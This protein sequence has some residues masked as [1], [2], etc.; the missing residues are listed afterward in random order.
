MRG[1][2]GFL[3]H[4]VRLTHGQADVITPAHAILED[5][6]ARTWLS[7][8]DASA[9]LIEKARTDS[10]NIGTR[11]P[12]ASQIASTAFLYTVA[13][14]TGSKLRGC[15]PDELKRSVL[16]PDTD[17]ND[18]ENT[19]AA[20]EK[21][22]A[23][24]HCQ[25][26]RYYF[27]VEEQPD[28]KVE[29]RS[30]TVPD[31]KAREALRQIW[32]TD[33]FHDDGSTVF[34][35]D[36]ESARGQLGEAGKDRLRFLLV[37]RRLTAEERH[38]LFNGLEL[39]NQVV[40]LEPKDTTF[41][42]DRNQDLLKWAKRQVAAQELAALSED[43]ERRAIYERIQRQDKA[44]CV[45][46]IRKAGLVLIRWEKFGAN[47][48]EDACEEEVVSG[49]EMS[50][51]DV[52]NFLSTGLFPEQAFV[53]HL[54]DRREA[55]Y[56]KTVKVIERDYQQVLGYPI[57]VGEMVVR[58]LKKMCSESRIGLRHSREN[59]CGRTPNLTMSELREA[60]V[61]APFAEGGAPPTQA[62]RPLPPEV[63][64]PPPVPGEEPPPPT[65]TSLQDVSCLPKPSTGELRTEVAS[66][67]GAFSEVR[68]SE[69][70]LKIFFQS[71]AGDLSTLPSAFRGS[72]SG[73]GSVTAEIQ[74]RKQGSFT[75][76]EIEQ[77]VES[78][79]SLVGATYSAHLRIIVSQK[80]A[81]H[82]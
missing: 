69:V 23:H 65:R 57:P 67:L 14:P 68:V 3:G 16:G 29:F 81:H 34:F 22:G 62:P 18:F 49:R 26:G 63:Q 56:G 46:S 38:G 55:I 43:S 58:A 7:D 11:Y 8:L 44:N 15:T 10:A 48:S 1:A 31:L 6:D 60:T 35:S 39:R 54:S 40:L 66:R 47:E 4:L 59:A 30:L 79:P 37:P 74:I 21:Y 5:R 13:S 42:L 73:S 64:L 33:V 9:D 80:E 20:F 76:G 41:D 51:G 70:T 78:L 45:A 52:L 71:E 50:R 72:L 17:V 61:D 27:D 19:L 2:L 12:L 77:M 75:K 36:I 53:D 28:A 82:A 25:E 24:F 32:L